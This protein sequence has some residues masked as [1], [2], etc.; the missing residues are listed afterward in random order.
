M[1][2]VGLAHSLDTRTV[3]LLSSRL[4]FT[5]LTSLVKVSGSKVA[6]AEL[7]PP[8]TGSAGGALLFA[9]VLGPLSTHTGRNT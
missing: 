7:T 1:C 8:G 6:P 5:C 4:L 2:V 9:S 3:G